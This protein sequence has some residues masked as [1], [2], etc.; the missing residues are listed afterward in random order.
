MNRKYLTAS[1]N[2]FIFIISSIIYLY[3]NKYIGLLN[4][5]TIIFLFLC[6]L[7]SFFIFAKMYFSKTN[8]IY[9]IGMIICFILNCLFIHQIIT[10]SNNYSF[11]KNYLNNNQYI[12]Y[13]VLVLKKT[14]TYNN[15][16]KLENKKIGTIYGSDQLIINNIKYEQKD[17]KTINKLM[18]ALENAQIQSIILTDEDLI[19]LKEQNN[20]TYSQLRTIHQFRFTKNS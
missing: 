5:T 19:L 10:I 20:L 2:V 14:P 17:Y 4:N 16:Y 1:F 18:I 12:T 3:I 7:F 11:I 13:N 8:I 6:F 9:N 15:I